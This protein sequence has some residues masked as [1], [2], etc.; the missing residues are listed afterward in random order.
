VMDTHEVMA[1]CEHRL[2][3]LYRDGA[4]LMAQPLCPEADNFD[5]DLEDAIR[6][7]KA[8]ILAV[9]DY[10]VKADRMILGSSAFLATR[11]PLGCPLDGKGWEFLEKA[12]RDAYRSLSLETLREALNV[13]EAFALAVFDR[14]RTEAL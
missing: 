5:P 9:L 3:I 13:R 2:I 11:W 14:F 7:H 4:R 10:E 1:E 12:L 6:R 8:E